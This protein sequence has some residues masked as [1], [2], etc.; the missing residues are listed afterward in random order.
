M[1]DHTSDSVFADIALPLPV[2]RFFTYKVPGD[3]AESLAP[4]CRVVVPFGNRKMTG[5]LISLHGENEGKYKIKSILKQIDEHPLLHG[6]LMKLAGWMAEYYIHPLGEILRA[7]LP[8]GVKGKGRKSS[9]DGS[10]G[11]FPREAESPVL[12]D[13]QNSA[14]IAITDSARKSSADTFLLYG[15]T[16]S[17]K[18]E[19][20][21]RAIEEALSIGR[22]ALVLVPEIALI[23]QATAR[24][25]HRFG[26]RVAVLHSRLT[27]PQRSSIWKKASAGEIDVVIGPRSAVFVPLKGLGIIV[28]DEEQDSS[29]N[30]E[31]KPHYN[32]VDVAK[33]RGK[34]ENAVVILGSATP[35]LESYDSAVRGEIK[36]F[37]ISSRPAESKLPPVEVIDMRGR[38]EIISSELLEGLDSCVGRGDQAIILINR[39][40]HANYIQ[41]RKCGW[42]DR[43]PNC[44]ISLTYHSK[45]HRLVCHYCGYSRGLPE[46]CPRCGDFKIIQ[47]GIG[48]Q[49]IEMELSNLI[50]SAKILRMDFDTT[51]GKKS[52]LEILER[53]GKREAEILLGTRMVAKGHHYPDVTLVGVIAA[54]AGLNFPDFRAAERTFQLLSQ[55]AGRTG[56]GRKKGNVIIQAHAPEHYL[57]DYLKTHD[58]DGF[59]RNELVLRK[60]FRY[61]PASRLILFTVSSRSSRLALEAAERAKDVIVSNGIIDENDILGPTPAVVEKLR[62]RFRFL[63]LVRG[64]EKAGEK[65]NL[66][67]IF[68]KELAESR[69]ADIQWNVDP[70]GL[71]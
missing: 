62:G 20:Y 8:A 66:V 41:C 56:R 52:H 61:P 11:D 27:G 14:F 22:T 54:D 17:G 69:N 29:F 18:T 32:A 38:D 13:D 48:S 28:V 40:G 60:Q 55:A 7:M 33:F 67:E 25:R 47:K 65:Q 64:V 24:F 3:L 42:I 49:R 26:D 51:S 71:F 23:P 44:S 70:A 46:R 43:C 30:Q 21:M 68:K 57:Y 10:A 34:N 12:G 31:E 9:E 53:F 50:P 63:V 2:D 35:S 5:Y 39:R 19:V 45:G 6:D 59:A 4:G 15:V 1:T 16:G 36:S 58:F 37:R